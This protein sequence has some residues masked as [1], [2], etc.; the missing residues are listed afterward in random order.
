MAS[1][2]DPNNNSIIQIGVIGCAGIARK[3]CRAFNLSPN[4][5]L[6]AIASR[7]ID[8]AKAFASQNSFSSDNG[9]SAAVRIYGSYEELVDDKFV[10]AVYMPLPTSLHLHW[11]LLAAQKKKHL[12]LEKPAALNVG[13]LDRI[14]EACESNGVQFMD[15]SMWFHHPRTARM[16]ELLS[17]SNLFGKLRSVIHYCNTYLL[18]YCI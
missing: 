16:K 8:K 5:T 15:G 12:L 3:L 2:E 13:E 7:S 14:L 6:S 1:G 11:A 4:A 10:D 17:D 9:T 18:Y